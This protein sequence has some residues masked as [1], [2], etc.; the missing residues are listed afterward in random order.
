VGRLIYSA[1]ASLDGYVED[2][3][4]MAL[5]LAEERRFANGVV[6]VRY[7]TRGAP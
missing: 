7:S 2:E 3:H 5:E 6:Y 4:G 1:I